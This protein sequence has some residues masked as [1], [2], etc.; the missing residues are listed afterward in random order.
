MCAMFRPENNPDAQASRLAALRARDKAGRC[1]VCF[2]GESRAFGS[3]LARRN[4]YLRGEAGDKVIGTVDECLRCGHIALAEVADAGRALGIAPAAL[5][6]LCRNT[7]KRE[8][9][10]DEI[11]TAAERTVRFAE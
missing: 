10:A 7:S 3:R 8:F 6:R 9:S 1:A 2:T 5:A 4:V 11:K